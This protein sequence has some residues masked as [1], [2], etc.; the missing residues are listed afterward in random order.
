MRKS[1]TKYVILGLLNETDLTGYEIK[2]II[3]IRFS[4]FWN[5]SYGQLYPELKHLE[6]QG[7]IR[8]LKF[9]IESHRD[10][11]RYSITSLGRIELGK[12]LA[13]PAQQETVRFEILL[14]M[15]FS[16][17]TNEDVMIGHIAEFEK[18]HQ[19]QLS[20]L[21]MFQKELTAI[22][23][24]DNHEDILRVIDFGQ[25]VYAAYLD[26]SKETIKYL[27]KRKKQ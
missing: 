25:K 8:S 19:K 2:K 18:N 16:S 9:D 4:F 17:L 7:L 27:E 13:E 23:D 26:W 15:Y 6:Q 12:W 11:I 20:V 21:N 22:R 24:A 5:E 10:I 3:D 14:K 1:K